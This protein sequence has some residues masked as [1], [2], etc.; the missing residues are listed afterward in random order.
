MKTVKC[1]RQNCMKVIV[2]L[3]VSLSAVAEIL[4]AHGVNA[5]TYMYTVAPKRGQRI[6]FLVSFKHFGQM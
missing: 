3:T 6:L 2:Y 4:F 1:E 5:H